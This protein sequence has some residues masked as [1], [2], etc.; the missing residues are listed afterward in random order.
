MGVGGNEEK[1]RKPNRRE[2]E[3]VRA[4]RT[5]VVK[6]RRGGGVRRGAVQI[7]VRQV[8]SNCHTFLHRLRRIAADAGK[9]EGMVAALLRVQQ[10][11]DVSLPLACPARPTIRT[12]AGRRNG[13]GVGTH[14]I[15]RCCEELR[16]TATPQA[17]PTKRFYTSLGSSSQEK[18]ALYR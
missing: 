10:A 13:L 7:R 9:N 5:V 8:R 17:Q 15:A 1:N 16:A 6:G 11:Q 2:R 18:K 14:E 12:A 4:Q 3:T